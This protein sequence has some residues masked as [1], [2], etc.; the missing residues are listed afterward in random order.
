MEKFNMFTCIDNCDK[1]LTSA[2]LID[3][4]VPTVAAAQVKFG[5]DFAEPDGSGDYNQDTPHC[6]VDHDGQDCDCEDSHGKS[7]IRLYD[8]PESIAVVL[9]K[10]GVDESLN[11]SDAY[12]IARPFMSPD[13]H[14]S[15]SHSALIAELTDARAQVAT[16]KD[17]LGQCHTD[18]NALAYMSPKQYAVKRL[19]YIN[20]QVTAALAKVA[21]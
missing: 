19:D 9:A 20:Q 8:V 5:F 1:S 12:E 14:R 7:I 3:D 13:P 15:P 2:C 11:F 21:P 16:L 4:A 17:A 10:Q 6:D 18:T